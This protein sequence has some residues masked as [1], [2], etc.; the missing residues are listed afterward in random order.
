M[1][2]KTFPDQDVS[3]NCIGTNEDKLSVEFTLRTP[4]RPARIVCHDVGGS[5]E[6]P[7]QWADGIATVRLT[8][9][10]KD[11]KVLDA[12]VHTARSAWSTGGSTSRRCGTN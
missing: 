9:P 8:M 3:M 12:T 5:N 1:A 6:L 2:G 10:A 11:V 7:F 4:Q